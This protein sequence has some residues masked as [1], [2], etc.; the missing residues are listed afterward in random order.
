MLTGEAES[1]G[2]FD[3]LAVSQIEKRTI[4][5]TIELFGAAVTDD[6]VPLADLRVCKIPVQN[7][8]LNYYS[9]RKL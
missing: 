4:G 3:E 6:T 7:G 1:I 5:E 8:I 9:I 2:R